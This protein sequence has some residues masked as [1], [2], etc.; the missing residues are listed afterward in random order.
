MA[1]LQ[2]ANTEFTGPPRPLFSTVELLVVYS[3][4]VVLAGNTV[5]VKGTKLGKDLQHVIREHLKDLKL[6]GRQ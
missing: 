3:T 4:L 6:S 1:V 5:Q 2:M